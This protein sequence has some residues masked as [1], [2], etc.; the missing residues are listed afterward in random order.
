[1]LR[2]CRNARKFPRRIEADAL[3]A[4]RFDLIEQRGKRPAFSAARCTKNP[5]VT[6]KEL[7]RRQFQ[8]NARAGIQEA[9]IERTRAQLRKRIGH[10]LSQH[11]RVRKI[12]RITDA[13]VSTQAAQQLVLFLVNRSQQLD[14]SDRMRFRRRSEHGLDRQ[15]LGIRHFHFSNSAQQFDGFAVDKNEIPNGALG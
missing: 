6:P 2:D 5:A 15:A 10:E 3:A 11:G 4:R 9:E 13:R 7:F 1:V 12:D 14:S 8:S